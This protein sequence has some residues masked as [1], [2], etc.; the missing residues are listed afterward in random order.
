MRLKINIKYTIVLICMYLLIFQNIL[1]KYIPIMQYFDEILALCVIPVFG[2]KMLDKKNKLELDNKDFLIII[3]ILFLFV[4]GISSN[5]IYNIQPTSVALADALLIFKFFFTYFL[6]KTCLNV[7]FIENFKKKLRTHVK[8]I[9]YVFFVLTVFNYVFRIWPG[10]YRFGIMT[11]KLFYGHST[12]LVAV[13]IFLLSLII[14]LTNNLKKEKI[15]VFAVSL[16]LLSTLRF[17]AIGALLIISGVMILV[18]HS[19]KKISISKFGLL[20][21]IGLIFVWNQIEYYYIE[22]DGSARNQLTQK[23]LQIAK[24]YFPLG[25][26]FGTYGS[27]MSGISYSP[28]YYIYK[29]NNIY[30]LQRENANFISDTFW[31]MIIGQFGIL[32]LVIYSLI[33]IILFKNIQDDFNV[34]NKQLYLSKICCFIYLLISSTSETAFVHP[35]SIPLALVIGI[36]SMKKKGIKNE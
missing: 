21:L 12:S 23:S 3:L 27:Y 11:N 20:V 7:D 30:G 33:L 34:E 6:A 19:N 2:I 13:C 26:G 29:L 25:A 8:I 18:N 4:T 5:I 1:Q 31:P 24:D 17:K 10:E 15:S 28:L 9:L 32:G 22:L 16:V 35:M 36:S 14:L